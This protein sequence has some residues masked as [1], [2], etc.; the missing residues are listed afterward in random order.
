MDAPVRANVCTG[1][2]KQFQ[3]LFVINAHPGVFQYFKSAQ[4]DRFLLILRQDTNP[5][6]D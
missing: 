6:R 3:T 5:R 1:A 4:K 2:V